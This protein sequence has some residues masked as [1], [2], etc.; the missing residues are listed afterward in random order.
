MLTEWQDGTPEVDGITRH[1]LRT[2][3]KRGD[4][5]ALRLLGYHPDPEVEVDRLRLDP[6]DVA[7]GEA[8]RL[9]CLVRSTGSSS[10]RVMI[11][12]VVF[13]Q[14]ARGALSPKVFK[15]KTAELE[16]GATIA[17]SRKLSFQNLSTR[18]IYPGPHAVE[19]Q[20]NGSRLG[21]IDFEV[22][23]SRTS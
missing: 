14:K 16:P 11:D 5:G 4:P 10:Q 20:V 8:T 18:T 9:H 13:F 15:V 19:V 3:L 17:V 23:P 12:L 21:R 2:L 6:P 7:V 22:A 1:G